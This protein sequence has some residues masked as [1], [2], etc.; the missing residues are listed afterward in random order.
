MSRPEK[1]I[2]VCTQN[3][4]EGHPRGSCASSGC[5]DVINEFMNEI[6]ARNLTEKIS[7][8]NTGCLGPCLTGPTV[9]VYPEGVMYGKLTKDDVKTI[10]DQHIMSDVFV[11]SLMVPPELW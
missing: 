8:T 6:Q 10:V 3:R 7:L 9:L 1:H 5:G 4:S 2:F 11:E